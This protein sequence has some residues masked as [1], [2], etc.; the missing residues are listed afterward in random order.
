MMDLNMHSMIEFGDD[1]LGHKREEAAAERV[2]TPCL[3]KEF[4]RRF[5]CT[6]VIDSCV[7]TVLS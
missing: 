1:S 6:A 7:R 4:P 2:R 5:L 3:T